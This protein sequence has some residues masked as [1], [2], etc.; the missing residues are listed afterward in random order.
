MH[1]RVGTLALRVRTDLEG[2]EV[3][4]RD[5]AERFTRDVI[6]R[7]SQLLDAGHPGRVVMMKSLPLAFTLTE[8]DSISPD[9]LR[10]A[11][12]R[13]AEELARSIEASL[14]TDGLPPSPSAEVAVFADEAAFVA[15]VA[16]S[17]ARATR[18]WFHEV[19]LR[20]DVFE[21]LV[22]EPALALEVLTRLADTEQL[23]EV[24]AQIPPSVATRLVD[25]VAGTSSATPYVEE[26]DG[27]VILRLVERLASWPALEAPARRLAAHAH[28]H[29]IAR[30]NGMAS[31]PAQVASWAT[32]A[33]A[34]I[35]R[36]PVA[37]EPARAI[38]AT[39]DQTTAY[40][41][42][43]YLVPALLEL[44]VP[45]ALWQA[46]LPEGSSIASALAGLIP[47]DDA[48]LDV[49]AGGPRVTY[50][51][52]DEQ[53]HEIARTS[54]ARLVTTL[55]RGG[56]AELPDGHASFVDGPHGRL[57]IVTARDA[58]FVLFAWP[59]R[60][61]AEATAG[62]AALRAQWPGTTPLFGAP[63]VVELDRSGQIR[64]A[65]ASPPAP[66]L[67][68]G[69]SCAAI[70][71][72]SL[73]AGLPCQLAIS[74]LGEPVDD[75]AAWVARRLA[76]Y[77]RIV[78]LEDAIEIWVDVN[79]VDLELRSAGIDRDPGFVPWLATTIRIR[80]EA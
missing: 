49:I 66:W 7:C 12:E 46:C 30:A 61:P 22:R 6:E 40:T 11:I 4:V 39:R 33:L 28:A 2:R 26:E 20:D 68:S 5:L 58:P 14:P 15:S 17:R 34:V 70:A 79:A 74:R 37:L 32:R 52:S 41:G 44:G 29:R 73:V 38:A 21:R 23:I 9:H 50:T 25:V 60:T 36:D 63:S 53:L 80:F 13:A 64:H 75:V 8:R 57:L 19:A 31:P 69:R 1:D 42:L 65:H 43:F 72:A 56:R 27:P 55:P 77:G 24:V 67:V 76:V 78:H 47:C 71:L 48:A 51:V 18:P 45:E 62:L 59:A 16:V 35:A 3:A 54:I 10:T